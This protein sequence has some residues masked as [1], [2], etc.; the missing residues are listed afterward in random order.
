M[1]SGERKTPWPARATGLPGAGV[2]L[3]NCPSGPS[4]ASALLAS[5]QEPA[6]HRER[7]ASLLRWAA[8]DGDLLAQAPQL[9]RLNGRGGHEGRG[10]AG[11]PMRWRCIPEPGR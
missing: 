9:R 8:L 7:E 5:L 10:T 4:L 1:H 3:W 11:W 6:D 2:F